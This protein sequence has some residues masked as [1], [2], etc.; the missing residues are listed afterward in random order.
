MK[1]FHFSLQRVLEWR[2]L[3]QRTEEEKLSSLQQTLSAL[4]MRDK[5]LQTSLLKS[6]L[7]LRAR[8]SI[9]AFEIGALTGFR[10]RIE[11]ERKN[12]R[13]ATFKV[14]C[15]IDAQRKKLLQARRDYRILEKLRA[16]KYAEW[17]YLNDREIENIAADAFLAQWTRPE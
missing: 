6:E 13:T 9:P 7:D 8:P 1:A 5:E 10:R 11:L 14:E 15:E 17:S 16:R 3:Q 2:A 12:L 4:L